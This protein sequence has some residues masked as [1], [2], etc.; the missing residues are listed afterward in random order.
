M[1]LQAQGALDDEEE[2]KAAAVSLEELQAEGRCD[3]EEE[4]TAVGA[5]D[6]QAQG[7]LTRK[8]RRPPPS[9][10]MTSLQAARRRARSKR[11]TKKSRL[12]ILTVVAADDIFA[13]I[14][15]TAEDEK[16]AMF[17]ANSGPTGIS[18]VL[19]AVSG[20]DHGKVS[21]SS[22]ERSCWAGA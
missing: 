16:T 14:S 12:K 2:E 8:R 10:L 11:K 6:L 3:E 13:G 7:A 9:A 20:N 4:K 1:D 21:R 5:E 17:E 19:E 15:S 22:K 18:C